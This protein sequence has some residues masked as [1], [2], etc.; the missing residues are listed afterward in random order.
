MSDAL[1]EIGLQAGERV[2][3]HSA[4]RSRWQDGVVLQREKDGSIGLRDTDG[5]IRAVPVANVEVRTTGPRGGPS[6]EP[7]AHR[8]GRVEQLKLL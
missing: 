8:A 2:R 5:R 6:W 1:I 3:F 4:D 7:L